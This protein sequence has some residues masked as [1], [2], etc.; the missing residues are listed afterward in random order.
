MNKKKLV[1]IAGAVLMLGVGGGVGAYVMRGAPAA[2]AKEPAP[3]LVPKEEAGEAKEEAKVEARAAGKHYAT[4]YYA[5]PQ[6]FTVNTA[7][8]AFVQMSIG[9]A[10][11]YDDRVVTAI[12]G[13]EMALRSAV[14]I[15]MTE[16]NSEVL[17]TTEGKTRLLAGLKGAMNAAL[18]DRTGFGGID[19]V[20]FTSFVIQ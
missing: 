18:K 12:K 1:I 15:A 19:Q 6:A 8:G 17:A 4:A 7:D 14:L 5:F 16:T 20:Y 10:T 3:K 2:E 11:N 13:N 9:V